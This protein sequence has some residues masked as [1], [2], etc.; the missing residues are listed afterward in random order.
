MHITITG[1][2]SPLNR[3]HLI[4]EIRQREG[5]IAIGPAHGL[6]H[7]EVEVRV[8]KRNKVLVIRRPLD[9]SPQA[10][11]NFGNEFGRGIF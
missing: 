10:A 3:L 11:L 2:K 4:V 6:G 7:Q 5:A 8:K 1:P 9:I